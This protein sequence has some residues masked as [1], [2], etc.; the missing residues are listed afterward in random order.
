MNKTPWSAIELPEAINNQGINMKQQLFAMTALAIGLVAGSTASAGSVWSVSVGVGGPGYVGAVTVGSPWA[1]AQVWQPAPVCAP[2]P[3][4]VAP[5]AAWGPPVVYAPA[6][7]V[8]VAPRMVPAPYFWGRP[9]VMAAPCGW[10]GVGRPGFVGYPAYPAH[11][12][13]G[14]R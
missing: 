1:A 2:P 7:V 13:H 9:V 4:F 5:P 6:P 10:P 3:V 14:W 11:H 12:G 8:Y